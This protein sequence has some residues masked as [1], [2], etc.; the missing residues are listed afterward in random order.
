LV[1]ADLLRAVAFFGIVMVNDFALTVAFA[2]LAGI[3][4]GLFTPAALAAIPSLVRDESLPA[5]TSVFGAVAD[6]G[7]TAGPALA[8]LGFA[9]SGPDLILVVNA[10]TF[11]VSGFVL[12]TI[13]FGAPPSHAPWQEKESLFGEARDGLKAIVQM[14]GIRV[15]IA[16]SAVGLFFGGLF[17]VA[18]LLFATQDLNAGKAGFSILATVYGLG[19]VFGSLAG[20]RGGEPSRLKRGFLTGLAVLGAGYLLCGIA[21]NF[22]VALP[23]FGLAGFGNGLVLVYER[24]LVQ[25]AV[26]DTLMA[27]VFGAKDALTAWS[28]AI[29]FVTAGAIIAAI[30]TRPLIILAGVGSL[31]AW[32]ISAFSLR[33]VWSEDAPGRIEPPLEHRD[34]LPA[35]ES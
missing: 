22:L 17:N 33:R 28:F 9:I 20:G 24:L 1:I 5:A 18:E 35:A 16:A 26:P 13:G 32:L 3:G 27:R 29:A 8:A 30:N 34:G 31:L 12:S 6:V 10:V 2:V 25:T 23:T 15:V 4:T 7:F 19:F 21:P 11:A 14:R